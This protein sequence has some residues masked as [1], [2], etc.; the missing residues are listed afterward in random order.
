MS[1]QYWL[2]WPVRSVGAKYARFPCPSSLRLP[3]IRVAAPGVPFTRHRP[4][5][6]SRSKHRVGLLC[7]LLPIAP[8]VP[9]AG[10]LYCWYEVHRASRST[11]SERSGPAIRASSVS[12]GPSGTRSPAVLNAAP[13]TPCVNAK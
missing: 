10:P 5:D 12:R 4:Q 6:F 13:S 2:N 1:R 7:I 8:I 11:T 9:Q 3:L